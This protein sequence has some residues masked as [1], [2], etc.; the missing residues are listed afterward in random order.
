M[1]PTTNVTLYKYHSARTKAR[2]NLYLR[3]GFPARYS[4]PAWPRHRLFHG[5]GPPERR[6]LLR[7]IQVPQQKLVPRVVVHVRERRQTVPPRRVVARLSP[8]MCVVGMAEGVC[9]EPCD[10]KLFKGI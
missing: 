5:D 6:P 10:N 7:L 1:S 2:T 9:R 3:Y 4:Q 8:V